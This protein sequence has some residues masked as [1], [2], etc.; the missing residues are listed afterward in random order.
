M[1]ALVPT[2]AVMTLLV[3]AVVMANLP[4]VNNRVF[5]LGPAK[6]PKPTVWH[7]VELLA[8]VALTCVIGRWLEGHVGQVTSQRW[9]FYAVWACVMITLAFPG[10][11]WR[12]LRRGGR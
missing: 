12:Y 7:V 11:V 6:A 10:F 9:E 1:N 8:Y 4:F 5:V 3:A 2:W